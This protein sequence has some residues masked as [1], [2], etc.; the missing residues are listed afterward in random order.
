MTVA[1]V[2]EKLKEFPQDALVIITQCSDYEEVAADDFRLMDGKR[3]F[4][5]IGYGLMNHNGHLMTVYKKWLDTDW[6]EKNRK[7]KPPK[8]TDF[9]TAVHIG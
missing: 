9:V 7:D 5:A 4:D 1:E 2:I 8:R 3:E 6:W